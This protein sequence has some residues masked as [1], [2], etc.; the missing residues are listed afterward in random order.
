[1]KKYGSNLA[2]N[3]MLFNLIV[4][5]VSLFIIAFLLINPIAKT[6]TVDPPVVLMIEMTWEDTSKRDIDLYLR[7]P[8][9]NIVYY[10][11]RDN[12]YATLKRDDLGGRSDTYIV[13]GI[14]HEVERNYE[15]ITLSALPDGDYVINAHFFG[16]GTV[17]DHNSTEAISIRMTGLQP[18]MIYFEA[19]LVTAY[20]KEVTAA[21]FKVVNGEIQD[22]HTDIQVKLRTT[23]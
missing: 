9:G 21:A 2:F 18:F 5:F 13:N 14:E 23:R 10:A 16:L 6:G 11:S 22:L 15:I 20:R 7:G 19:D 3:D 8:D 17:R 1:M 4:G 12:G